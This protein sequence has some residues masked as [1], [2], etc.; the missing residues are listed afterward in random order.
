VRVALAGS[1]SS[2]GRTLA[3]L[4]EHKLDIVAV[5]GLDPRVSAGVSDYIDLGVMARENGLRFSY[6][7]RFNQQADAVK[8]C[9]PDI[10]FVVGLSQ[11]VS[12]E[13]L[14]LPRFGCVGFHPT[15]LPLGRGRAP[16]AWILLDNCPAAATFFRMAAG[17][18][19]G[20]IYCQELVPVNGGDD[21]TSLVGKMDR[22]IDRALDQWL[23]VLASG[24][25]QACPQVHERA[26]WYAG[27]ID[28]DGELPWRESAKD[29]ERLVRATTRPY[30]G[31][32]TR[33]EQG[34][35]R[36]WRAH[37]VSRRITGVPGAVVE[38]TAEGF[39]VQTG[40]GHLLISDCTGPEEWRPR[41]GVR[42]ASAVG[43]SWPSVQR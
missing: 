5:F 10:L 32:W 8:K 22:A 21:V 7:D 43:L 27:R 3:K 37:A 17:V 38:V 39:V 2:S 36:V 4:I 13:L 30:P 28:A 16:L 29:L 34:V 33:S 35:I 14:D 15:A 1:V 25:P 42:L 12:S 11:I 23:P 9:A 6:F 18:D 24:E 41:V 26:T 20:P 19:D 31:A 40:H